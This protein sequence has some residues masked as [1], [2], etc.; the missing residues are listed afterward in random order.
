MAIFNEND[1]HGERAFATYMEYNDAGPA[2]KAEILN[3]IPPSLGH[4][5]VQDDELVNASVREL[6][7][8]GTVGDTTLIQTEMY[9]TV[10]SG[11]EPVKAMRNF[12]PIIRLT[13]GNSMKIPKGAAGAYAQDVA[14]GAEIKIQDQVYDPT[15][16]TVKKIGTRPLITNEMINDS[17][18]SVIA[19]EV[20]KAGQRME[21]KLNRDVLR[22]CLEA[23]GIQEHD[24]AGT[25][26]GSLA[27][28]EAQQ[29]I[30]DYNWIPDKAA[31]TG[32]FQAKILQEMFP[33]VN[34]SGYNGESLKTG[35]VGPEILGMP[36]MKTS[37]NPASATYTWRYTTD[38]DIGG[39]VADT[40]NFAALVIREDIQVEN[41][42]DPIRQ[43]QGSVLSMRFETGILN[44]TAGC[45]IE[46]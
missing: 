25:N 24:T 26:Q 45:R 43:L 1:F 5:Y 19:L 13:S 3:Q 17:Q 10:M 12:L 6:L 38:G 29:K 28:L 22:A 37:V 20:K 8:A 15:T 32:R 42:A 21:N 9:N 33:A 36:L 11:A 35:S 18:Y 2:R 14:E 39:L 41:Y 27:L 30:E 23:S 34:E 44:G 16:V 4:T 40:S 46:Y 31:V 7:V